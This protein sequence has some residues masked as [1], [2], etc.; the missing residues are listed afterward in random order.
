MQKKAVFS[1]SKVPC[2]IRYR[3]G[4]YYANV[5]VSGKLLRRSLDT[6]DYSQA[7]ARLPG[8]L[9]EL[10]GAKN[11]SQ[12]G[13]LGKAVHD[14]AHRD[15]P[16]IKPT[17]RHYYRQLSTSLA[18]TGSKMPLDPMGLSIARVTLADLKGLMDRFATTA[19]VTRYNGALAL[20]RRTYTTAVDAGHVGSNV[21]VALK[22]LKPPKQKYD[23][24]TAKVFGKIVQNILDQRKRHSKATAMAVE[25][26]A[27][28][29]LR[30]SEAQALQWRDIKAGHLVTRTAKNDEIRQIPLIPAAKDLLDRLRASGVPT[31]P[32]D[33]VLLIKSPRIA[34]DGA[35]ERLG[36]DHMRVHDLRHLFATRCIEAGVDL[37]ALASWLGHKDGGVLCAQV[38]GHL[39][40]KHST[41]MAGRVKA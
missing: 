9:A 40:K 19:A 11:A 7:V 29:G 27:Y 4:N 37:P 1:K 5:R 33:P 6:D 38:Y 35:C 3:G 22:R 2:L 36:V 8:V 16:A 28:T 26:L 12:A 13:T 24:P 30:I 32:D 21:P 14:E 41:A 20:L 31:G 34:L 23:L 18:A 25:L 17:T 39:C 10:R 15:D